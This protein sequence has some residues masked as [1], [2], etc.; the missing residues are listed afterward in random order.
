[1]LYLIVTLAASSN[2]TGAAAYILV[3]TV[4]MLMLIPFALGAA[5][6]RELAAGL[7]S[8]LPDRERSEIEARWRLV[9]AHFRIHPRLTLREAD[10]IVHD[11]FR[12]RGLAEFG[13]QLADRFREAH[14]TVVA[15]AEGVEVGDYRIS[16]AMSDLRALKDELLRGQPLPAGRPDRRSRRPEVG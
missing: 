14:A 4:V 6:R 13:S 16:Q 15:E 5:T 1:M 7:P 2:A 8:E 11:L 10:R 12:M 9:E 3:G